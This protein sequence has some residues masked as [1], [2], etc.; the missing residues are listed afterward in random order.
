MAGRFDL[1]RSTKAK[2]EQTA[3]D[4]RLRQLIAKDEDR[5]PQE[6][7][8]SAADVAAGN[9]AERQAETG[10]RLAATKAK[11]EAKATWQREADESLAEAKEAWQLKADE[12]LSSLVAEWQAETDERLSATIAERQAEA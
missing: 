11:R 8:H 10:G 1:L 12:R 7:E 6:E 3:A 9:R 2:D 4:K 5:E